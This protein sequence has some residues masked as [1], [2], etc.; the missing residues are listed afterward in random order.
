VNPFLKPGGPGGN[1]KLA[2][3][4]GGAFAGAAA[5]EAISHPGSFDP[6]EFVFGRSAGAADGVALEEP[7]L[8]LNTARRA[9]R[10][11]RYDEALAAA[12]Q[13]DRMFPGDSEIEQIRALILFAQKKYDAAAA[14]VW[15]VLN[16]GKV[17]DWPSLREM[18]PSQ[19][20][21]VE[22]L[23]A[24]QAASAEANATAGVHFLLAYHGIVLNQ[25]DAARRALMKT[26]EMQ[27]NN[28]LV[29]ELLTQL[30]P[31]LERP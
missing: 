30:P 3:P 26:R 1:A 27:P 28:R 16:R 29:D 17:W 15:N 7:D 22:H 9:F 8:A 21:Y 12:E 10:M 2:R 13:A 11:G 24:L 31:T 23:R 14:P 4:R 25:V 5:G 20:K 18:Y 6:F 19:E